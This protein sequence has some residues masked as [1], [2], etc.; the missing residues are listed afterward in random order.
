MSSALNLV[1]SAG[2]AI[3]GVFLEKNK[4]D[5]IYR[6]IYPVLIKTINQQG[7]NSPDSIKL[8]N[9]L[10]GLPSIGIRRR[11]FQRRYIKNENGWRELPITPEKIPYGHWH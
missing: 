4:A 7:R 1:Y 9:V 11:N 5:T 2:S 8:L 3:A 6:D 10:G